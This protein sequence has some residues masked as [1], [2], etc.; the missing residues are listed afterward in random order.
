MGFTLT[1]LYLWPHFSFVSTTC[2]LLGVF[3]RRLERYGLLLQHTLRQIW[4]SQSYFHVA[5][6]FKCNNR[7]WF[8]LSL[9]YG[10][11][12]HPPWPLQIQYQQYK[13]S[14]ERTRVQHVVHCPGTVRPPDGEIF[15]AVTITPSRVGY[16]W[17]IL[18]FVQNKWM[19]ANEGW[20]G[21][22]TARWNIALGSSSMNYSFMCQLCSDTLLNKYD[23]SAGADG[24]LYWG[25]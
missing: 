3:A 22:D 21:N 11:K 9:L 20:G 4:Q 1:G 12:G 17:C 14:I 23:S 2:C 10:L 16:K 15:V 5:W 24:I 13:R 7:K 8:M 19:K 25:I 18:D 6:H